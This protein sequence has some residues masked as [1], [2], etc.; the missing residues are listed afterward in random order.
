MNAKTFPH[1]H[2]DQPLDLALERLGAAGLDVLPVV[3][4][5]NVNKLEGVVTLGDLLAAF[6]IDVAA[7]RGFTKGLSAERD[8]ALESHRT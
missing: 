7:Q 6:G 5:A 8:V 4:R 3:S 1:V 2:S